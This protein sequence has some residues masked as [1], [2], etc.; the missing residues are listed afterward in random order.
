M[1]FL[2]GFLP[3]HLTGVIFQ[4]DEL[5]KPC[6]FSMGK[7]SNG[8]ACIAYLFPCWFWKKFTKAAQLQ[9]VR[10]LWRA[11]PFEICFRHVR[12]V[13]K[14]LDEWCFPVYPCFSQHT[15]SSQS[16]SECATWIAWILCCTQN[17][18]GGKFTCK[19]AQAVH[20]HMFYYF[21]LSSIGSSFYFLLLFHLGRI[22]F[23]EP[24]IQNVPKDF[25]IEM[26]TLVEESP[27]SQARRNVSALPGAR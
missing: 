24:N 27:P 16:I 25:E 22:S 23:A 20:W 11:F 6:P 18:W 2:L 12:L 8:S 19:C 10:R 26:P 1:L 5:H 13:F 21:G 15:A 7:T 14:L 17:I 3:L 9:N 4:A